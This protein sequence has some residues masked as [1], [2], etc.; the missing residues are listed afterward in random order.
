MCE[1]ARVSSP[2]S[3]KQRTVGVDP[4]W[5]ADTLSHAQPVNQILVANGFNLQDGSN[6]GAIY[7]ALGHAGPPHRV[8]K[9][10]LEPGP[11]DTDLLPLPV[12]VKGVFVVTQG[13]LRELRDM[14]NRYL[15]SG[16]RVADHDDPQ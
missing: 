2:E 11:G 7:F 13:R 5:P 15:D 10:E 9:S 1:T 16:D 14:L 4:R 8:N 3:P 12:E 6:D